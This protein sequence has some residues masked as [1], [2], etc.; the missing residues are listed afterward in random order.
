MTLPCAAAVKENDYEQSEA[1]NLPEHD[2]QQLWFLSAPVDGPFAAVCTSFIPDLTSSRSLFT[3][4][5]RCG[6]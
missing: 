4:V 2:S 1:G 6:L 5:E 3:G